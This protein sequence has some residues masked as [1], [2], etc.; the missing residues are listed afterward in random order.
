MKKV[1]ISSTS[2]DLAAYRQAAIKVCLKLELFPIAMENFPAVAMS[3]TGGSKYFLDKAD[4]YVGIFGFRYGSIEAGQEKSVTEIEFDHAGQRQLD[5]LCF[6]AEADYDHAGA[7]DDPEPP[8]KLAKIMALRDKIDASLIRARF[9]NV[10]AF[11]A[12]LTSALVEWNAKNPEEEIPPVPRPDE[13]SARLITDKAEIPG[14]RS[15]FIGRTAQLNEIHT[16][17]EK[18]EPVLLHGFS[19]SG[20]TSLA[21]QYASSSLPV[22]W[23]EVGTRKTDSLFQGLARLFDQ[24]T[25]AIISRASAE[26]R[27]QIL[28]RH[29]KGLN[30]RLVV[31]DDVWDGQALYYVL[32]VMK[33]MRVVVTSQRTYPLHV[34]R[35]EK[36][37]PSEAL[38]LLS[39][40]AGKDVKADP[41]AAELCQFL[42]YHA[43]ALEIA[44]AR[45]KVDDLAVTELRQ[46]IDIPYKIAMP[47]QFAREGRESMKQLIDASV[48]ALE[49]DLRDT[50]FAFG[51]MFVPGATPEILSTYL[52]KPNVEKALNLL[53]R[54]SL[55]R[56]D[57]LTAESIVYYR[58]DDLLWNYACDLGNHDQAAAIHAC[59][60]YLDNHKDKPDKMAWLE[61]ELGNL[62]G[63][64]ETAANQG[65][66]DVLVDILYGLIED[67]KNTA[68][69]DSRVHTDKSLALLQAA[70]QAA[71][72]TRSG[73]AYHLF[74]K[75]A[76]TQEHFTRALKD[77]L[78][79]HERALRLTQAAGNKG[80]EAKTL[81]RMASIHFKLKNPAKA[82]ELF[83]AAEKIARSHDEQ[84]ALGLILQNRAYCEAVQENYQKGREYAKEAVS[85]VQH[86]D[87]YKE[88]YFFSLHTLSECQLHLK[89]YADA[90]RT[91]EQALKLA[92]E[93]GVS[94]WMAYA[95]ENLGQVY[96]KRR[97][98]K[99][100]AAAFDQA[101]IYW[102][103]VGT[104]DDVQYVTELRTGLG[105]PVKA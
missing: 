91:L 50:F 67:G 93:Q 90:Q 34:I 10:D 70:S 31:L 6:L 48:N 81:S 82:N 80:R 46:E 55:I 64:A 25:Q 18:G 49:N 56:K 22:V 28:H 14:Y 9:K 29:L 75:L 2:K 35:V 20:K 60:V 3:A 77:A 85:I 100:A 84:M 83:D 88:V 101:L 87:N 102:N 95:Y 23:L 59:K 32:E 54:Y 16:A 45:M 44:G 72:T 73:K 104:L 103:Q 99:A 98:K 89:R 96:H 8:E 5:R 61:V 36:L 97:Q 19:G 27:S 92:Q 57:R 71:E 7:D 15:K 38:E 4:G 40:Y 13:T 39:T 74:S 17:L 79:N 69:F 63:A 26:D 62:L 41:A 21:A 68:Y 11:R 42:N 66:T 24:E 86:L 37:S 47:E 76:Y 12:E 30:A 53:E 51:A 105:Y 33:D 43:Y 78:A 65:K 52:G 94:R 1:F 58:M